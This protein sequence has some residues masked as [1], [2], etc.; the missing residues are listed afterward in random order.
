MC[1]GASS[2]Q[3][4]LQ[5]EQVSFYQQAQEEAATTFAEQ[6]AALAQMKSVYDPILAAGPNQEGFS[7]EEKTSMESTA[8]EGTATNYQN[9]AKAVN[10]QLAAEGG[11]NIPGGTTGAQEQ[12]KEEVATSAAAQLSSE[13]EQITQADYA[14]GQQNFAQATAA[15]ENTSGQYNPTSFESNAT[16]AGSA[17]ETTAAAIV[18]E[19]NSWMNAALGAAGSI[20]S[21]AVTQVGE[22]WGTCWVAAEIFGGWLDPRTVKVRRWVKV[23]SQKTLRGRIAASLYRRYGERL[24]CYIH[25]NPGIIRALCERVCRRILAA[26]N[27]SER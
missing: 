19:N 11:G 8:I 16:T 21:A 10:E 3:M 15:E 13:Q 20:G 4:E 1:G 2:T 14:T 5:Q 6:Q 12:L 23:E 22:N 9:A 7:P 25:G 18:N 26:Q 27:R 17:A 24:A